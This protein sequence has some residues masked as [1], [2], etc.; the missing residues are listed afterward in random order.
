LV[1]TAT[2]S[3]TRQSPADVFTGH[4]TIGRA[5]NLRLGQAELLAKLANGI[6]DRAL[7]EWSPESVE[8]MRS[9]LSPEGSRHSCLAS[10]ALNQVE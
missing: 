3:F 10:I 6:K 8:L 7:G 4:L 9:E 2:E 5:G 1:E